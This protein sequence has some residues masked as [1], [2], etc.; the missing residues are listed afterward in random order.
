MAEVKVLQARADGLGAVKDE[1]WVLADGPE[2]P[3]DQMWWL[4]P[5]TRTHSRM[6][7]SGS[8]FLCGQGLAGHVSKTWETR[9]WC[10]THDGLVVES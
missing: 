9:T 8:C 1:C 10:D 5:G 7:Q 4:T 3:G 6:W 2:H